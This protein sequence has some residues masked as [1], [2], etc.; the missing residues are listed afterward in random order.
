M[1]QKKV[2]VVFGATGN[3][4][5]SVIKSLQGDPKTA[6]EFR[7]RGITRDTSKPNAKAL[8][9]KGV[10]TVAADI[11]NKDQIKAA[12][13]GAYAVFAVTNYWEKMDAELEEQQGKNIADLSKEL[14]VQHL[15]WS[16]LRNVKDLTDGKFP[17][18]EH[19]DS[20]ANVEKYIREIG[21]P[22]TFFMPGFFMSNFEGFIRKSP[23]NDEYTLALPMPDDTPI[24]LF[25]AAGDTGKF[26]KGILTHR[27]KL[28]GK[29]VL[30]ATDYQTPKQIIETFKQ[31]FP[32]GGSNAEF[33]NVSKDDYKN[34][35]AGA[36]M[37]P[38]AQEELY[39]NMAFMHD[40]GY[41]GKE[42]LD[43]SH[44]I[45]DAKLTTFKDFLS[46]S[47]AFEALK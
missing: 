12:L 30:A 40:Y 9:E 31:C 7:I 36:G 24:P 15:I 45:L 29:R 19:F 34:A 21:I 20:K 33:V 25:D 46:N 38:K 32:N 23:P 1:A 43:E 26:V 44:E 8:E 5:G 37:P 10:E 2:V 28:L 42:S 14:G 39:E 13:Q 16:S 4:G 22:A 41:Y 6:E 35:L 17:N 18:V 11:N 27:D 3:Q 47:K